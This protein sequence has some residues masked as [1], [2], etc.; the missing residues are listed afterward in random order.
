VCSRSKDTKAPVLQWRG[1]QRPSRRSKEDLVY[2]LINDEVGTQD[3]IDH[4][5]TMAS[6]LITYRI[7][8]FFLNSDKTNLYK[9]GS[10]RMKSHIC[11]Q[12]THI[13]GSKTKDKIEMKRPMPSK[14]SVLWSN[15]VPCVQCANSPRLGIV[16]TR[17][18]PAKRI[19]ISYFVLGKFAW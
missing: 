7:N 6:S 1:W 12:C 13:T 10:Q 3:T 15:C 14:S 9:K 5:P 19:Q 8:A 17:H 4:L 16:R 18:K 11:V 2:C